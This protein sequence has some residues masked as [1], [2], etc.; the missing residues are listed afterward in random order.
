VINKLNGLN[1]KGAVGF[2]LSL[3]HLAAKLTLSSF[4]LLKFKVQ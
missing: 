2:R 4:L 1:I 3:S